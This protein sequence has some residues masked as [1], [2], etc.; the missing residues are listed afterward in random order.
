MLNIHELP[1]LNSATKYPSIETYHTLGQNGRLTDEVTIFPEGQVCLSE[2]V[3]G[4]NT[5][6]IVDRDGDYVIGEREG[7]LT[8]RGDRV[9]NPVQ[10]VVDAVIEFVEK[11]DLRPSNGDVRTYFVEVYGGKI[12]Q[13]HK[14]YTAGGHFGFCLFDVLDVPVDVLSWSRERIAAWRENGGQHFLTEDELMKVAQEKQIPLVPRLG[15]VEADDLPQSIGETYDW[16]GS[17]LSKTSVAL[18]DGAKGKPEGIVLRSSD[19][20]VIRKARFYNYGRTLGK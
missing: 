19:R 8:A 6:I 16:L 7:F 12:G 3:D 2:K 20:S 11:V 4:T 18:D 10:G 14:N 15:S 1:S 9:F 13:A 5:R 17:Y